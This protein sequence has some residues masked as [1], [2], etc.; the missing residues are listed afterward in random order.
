[1]GNRERKDS[2]NSENLNKIMRA[3]VKTVSM[4]NMRH[5]K[6][7]YCPNSSSEQLYNSYSIKKIG[8][9]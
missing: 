9:D 3:V 1:M 8:N 4:L 2:E 5:C 6:V 7:Q